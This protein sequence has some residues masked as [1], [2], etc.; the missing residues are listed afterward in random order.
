[1]AFDSSAGLVKHMQSLQLRCNQ[2]PDNASFECFL[3]K[4]KFCVNWGELCQHMSEIHSR[5]ERC[6]ICLEYLTSRELHKHLCGNEASIQCEYCNETFT[7]TIKL[8]KHLKTVHEKN[9]KLYRCNE[10]REF[11]PMMKLKEL[12]SAYHSSIEKP[13]MCYMCSKT[14]ADEAQLLNHEKTHNK[15]KKRNVEN[16][17]V[18]ERGKMK[19]LRYTN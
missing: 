11:F 13:F 18:A 14:F 5:N 7:T 15:Q 4:M 12:H 10:C 6:K 2:N 16:K 3:C 17:D 9:K 1:M 19:C 8:T